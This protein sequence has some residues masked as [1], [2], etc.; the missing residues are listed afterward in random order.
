MITYSIA[1]EALLSALWWPKKE[2]IY[3]YVG[4]P[5]WCRGKESACSAGDTGG[6]GLIPGLGRSSGEGNGNPP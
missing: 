5:W 6:L 3:V 2:G 1:Q 4:F